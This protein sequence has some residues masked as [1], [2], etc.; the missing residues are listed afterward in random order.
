[1]IHFS[2]LL[3]QKKK[4]EIWNELFGEEI[5]EVDSLKFDLYLFFIFFFWIL[6]LFS[7]F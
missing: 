4:M 6:C 2:F 5:S 3:N 7:I 1:M